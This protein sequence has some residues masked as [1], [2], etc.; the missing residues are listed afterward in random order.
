MKKLGLNKGDISYLY[1]QI[2]NIEN[3]CDFSRLQIC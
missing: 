3:R 1:A 2:K